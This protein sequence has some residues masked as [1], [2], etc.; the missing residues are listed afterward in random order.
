VDG[1]R[2]PTLVELE[3]MHIPRALCALGIGQRKLYLKLKEH[4]LLGQ[5]HGGQP[6][7]TARLSPESRSRE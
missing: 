1:G 3:L 6:L 5:R 4:K 7:L 2:L